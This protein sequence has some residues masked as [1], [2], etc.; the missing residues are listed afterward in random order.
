MV[1]ITPPG[2]WLD[3]IF[4]HLPLGSARKASP[5]LEMAQDINQNNSTLPQLP[6]DTWA[7]CGR[8]TLSLLCPFHLFITETPACTAGPQGL[9]S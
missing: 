6:P 5:G 8:K 9:A 4:L 3:H 1:I 7:L 2:N